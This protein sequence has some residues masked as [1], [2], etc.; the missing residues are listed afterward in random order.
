MAS[1]ATTPPGDAPDRTIFPDEAW[2]KVTVE[3]GNVLALPQES[4][5]ARLEVTV[6]NNSVDTLY[7]G[8]GQPVALAFRLLDTEGVEISRD[9]E[10]TPLT[11]DVPAGGR[12]KQA[13]N[14]LIPPQFNHRVAGIHVS[15]VRSGSFWIGNINR[16]HPRTVLL[17]RGHD[18][19]LL[20]RALLEAAEI[21]PLGRSNGLRWPHGTM[22]V[23][24]RH[25]I[26]YIP[27][28]KCGCTSL[29]SAM[30]ALAGVEQY[31]KAIE[32]GVHLI[33]DRFNTGVQLKDKSMKDAWKILASDE[34]FKFA[35]VREPFE[36]M[37]S[38][39]LEKFV[40]NRHHP[41]NLLHTRPVIGM[42]QGTD[43]IDLQRGISFDEF[44]AAVIGQEAMQLDPHWRP[45]YLYMENIKHLSKVYRLENIGKLQVDLCD[46]TGSSLQLR[47][48]NKTR[49]SD[50]LLTG[51][52]AMPSADIEAL[53]SFDPRSFESSDMYNALADYY[54][55][56]L[57]LY[58]GAE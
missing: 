35:V 47:H 58:L 37:V 16:N 1:K 57:E 11:T 2:G 40:Y 3:T 25:R 6:V 17:D 50:E 52:A 49:K 27:V 4:T 7:A 19:T 29:K 28:A 14:I 26:L 45:Q 20:Q 42:V 48:R 41:E 44:I 13:M 22:M 24:E 30:I 12:H 34:Y 9:G 39:Y 33:T 5:K 38:A 54:Q 10:T 8:S 56:D 46:I 18:M 55:R 51:I 31:E 36:R 32:L 23:S 21:W 53:G 15:L 43:A